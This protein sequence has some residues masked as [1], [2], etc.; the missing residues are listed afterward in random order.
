MP[1]S[2]REGLRYYLLYVARRLVKPVVHVIVAGLSTAVEVG[3]NRVGSAIW[4]VHKRVLCGQRSKIEGHIRIETRYASQRVQ[5][6]GNPDKIT[7]DADTKNGLFA[8]SVLRTGGIP[9]SEPRNPP[10][11][12]DDE[13]TGRRPWLNPN[14]Q[15]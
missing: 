11:S 5:A 2:F 12:V 4:G 7:V 6:A 1:P 15:R 14:E 8:K 13:R 9:N 10:G 3:V